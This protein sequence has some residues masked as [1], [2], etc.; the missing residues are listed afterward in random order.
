M[1]PAHTPSFVHVL[2]T[3]DDR[4]R[5][6]GDRTASIDGVIRAGR[7]DAQKDEITSRLRRALA[8]TA[9]VDPASID[10][11]TRDIEATYTMEGGALLPEPGSPE[12]R[13]WMAAGADAG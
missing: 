10:A 6:A 13:A 8:A 1:S 4:D 2:I 11:S 7:N 9:G 5:L 3:E 12:E